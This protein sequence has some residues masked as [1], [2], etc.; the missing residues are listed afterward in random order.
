MT[1]VKLTETDMLLQSSASVLH[2]YA[3]SQFIPSITVTF[4]RYPKIGLLNFAV[5]LIEGREGHWT[6]T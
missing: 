4:A 1:S 2:L 6:L 5:P 3:R